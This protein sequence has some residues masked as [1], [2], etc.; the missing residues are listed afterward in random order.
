MTSSKLVHLLVN[1]TCQ[2]YP[3]HIAI[4]SEDNE[5]SY[6]RLNQI[7]DLIA[8]DL[9]NQGIHSGD[10]VAVYLNKSAYMI[11]CL[12]GVLKAGAA[13]LP[14]DT[15]FPKERLHYMLTNS[16]AKLVIC[17]KEDKPIP[18]QMALPMIDLSVLDWQRNISIQYPKI[19]DDQPCYVIYTSGSTGRPKGVIVPHRPVVN[20]LQW[21][22]ERFQL[23][24][25]D[26]VL[27]QTTFSFDVSVWE[28]FWPLLV[29]ASCAAIKDEKKYDPELL[30]NFMNDYHVT[31]AQFVPTALH[32]I[33]D[34]GSL[35]RCHSLKHLF[36]GGEALDQA[37]ADQLTGQTDAQIHNLY[38]PTEATIFC[39][40]WLAQPGQSQDCVPIG[41]PIPHAQAYILDRSLNRVEP[42]ESGE[43]F[44]AGDILASGY[45]NNPQMTADRFIAN[46]F[47]DESAIE[48]RM[49]KTGDRVRRRHDGVLE[50]LGRI[51]RQIKIRGHRIELTEIESVLFK[52]PQVSNAAVTYDKNE[53]HGKNELKAY[54]TLKDGAQI[55]AQKIKDYVGQ[56]L[57]FYMCPS[58][59]IE[60]TKMPTLNNGK[61][62]YSQLSKAI[63]KRKKKMPI[64]T[65]NISSKVESQIIAVWEEVLNRK[66]IALNDN[67][68]DVGGNSLLMTKIHRHIKK[69]IDQHISIMD[70]FQYPTVKTLSQYIQQRQSK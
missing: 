60:L 35:T 44:L 49:Y 19:Q 3:L 43:L 50:Y 9:I 54:F 48:K 57:P 23:Q 45:I 30:V 52:L 14:L 21:M 46:P 68:F 70:M 51:D 36:S 11:A 56:Y 25:D 31:V 8:Y 4:H 37:L 38:G 59:F 64:P 18:V 1:E 61:T 28:M 42:G 29:G 55:N 58:I 69:H 40:H 63:L 47:A 20:Y 26:V 2:K 39:C 7:S 65:S 24:T 53:L 33:A 15:S 66:S 5:I 16:Q 34:A 10:V 12:L 6:E 17:D 41:L 32:I 27:A 62:D 22:Q 13:Y 67:F